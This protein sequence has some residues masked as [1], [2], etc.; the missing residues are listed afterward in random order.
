MLNP[1]R[2]RL[3][4]VVPESHFQ[5]YYYKFLIMNLLK[6]RNKQSCEQLPVDPLLID[7][8]YVFGLINIVLG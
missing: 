5:S 3:K 1:F 4:S 6:I 2:K 7:P 8:T